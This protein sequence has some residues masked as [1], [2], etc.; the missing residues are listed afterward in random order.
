MNGGD[1]GV[2]PNA[3]PLPEPTPRGDVAYTVH[4]A[5]GSVGGTLGLFWTRTVLLQARVAPR[6]IV[7]WLASMFAS[8]FT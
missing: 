1:P 2:P 4:D 8:S 6:K 5:E 7:T 3:S